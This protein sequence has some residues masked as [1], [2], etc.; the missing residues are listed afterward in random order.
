MNAWKVDLHLGGPSSPPR[1]D[2]R[3][4]ILKN[5]AIYAAGYGNVD[6]ILPIVRESFE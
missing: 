4:Q 2:H 6:D 3:T 5:S 1:A